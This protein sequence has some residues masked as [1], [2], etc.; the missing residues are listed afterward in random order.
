[1]QLL[2]DSGLAFELRN[3]RGESLRASIVPA[4]LPET[5]V[6]FPDKSLVNQET[7]RDYFFSRYGGNN[8]NSNP[9]SDDAH[10][11]VVVGFATKIPS[12][13]FPQ[14]Q[15]R[16]K[17]LATLNGWWRYGCFLQTVNGV[18]SEI[19]NEDGGSLLTSSP[20]P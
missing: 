3:S 16:L 12:S 10:A 4:L 13:F 18:A 20:L 17:D 6:G 2:H 8:N 19:G 15:V 1:M 9:N 5:P 11:T 7:L 14:L